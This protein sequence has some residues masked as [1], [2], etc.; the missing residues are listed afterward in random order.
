MGLSFVLERSRL[1]DRVVARGGELPGIEELHLPPSEDRPRLTLTP[2]GDGR[3]RVRASDGVQY[4]ETYS[5]ATRQSPH[6]TVVNR[7]GELA[8]TLDD[9]PSQEAVD[10]TQKR[11]F[12]PASEQDD[13]P[14]TVTL[15]ASSLETQAQHIPEEGLTAERLAIHLADGTT[16]HVDAGG[17]GIEVTHP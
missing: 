11:G 7:G 8:V 16:L 2:E 9:A 13:S 14:W 4:Y 3:V 15:Q 5:I 17:A 10:S 1:R 12:T 6:P